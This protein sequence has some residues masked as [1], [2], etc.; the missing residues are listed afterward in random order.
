MAKIVI[1]PDGSLVGVYSDAILPILQA[2]GPV[3]I[4][5][6]SSVNWNAEKGL[7]QAFHSRTGLFI[8]EGTNRAEVIREEV[9]WLETRLLRGL[10]T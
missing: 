10:E 2:L 4:Q 3:G 9:R 6:A 5:R 8:A 7:W 1:Q